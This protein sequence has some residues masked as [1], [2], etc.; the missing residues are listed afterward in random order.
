MA[1]P[2]SLVLMMFVNVEAAIVVRDALL[3]LMNGELTFTPAK[4]HS[5]R[6][7][8]AEVP[9]D[10]MMVV[11]NVTSSVVY[12]LMLRVVNVVLP[13]VTEKRG[14]FSLFLSSSLWAVRMNEI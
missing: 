6:E 10:L 7:R 4:V 5:D 2:S 8:E 12:V 14:T 13:S 1:P 3:R 9:L 11:P